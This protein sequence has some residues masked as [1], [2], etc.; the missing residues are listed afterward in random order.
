MR[1]KTTM[2]LLQTPISGGENYLINQLL[3]IICFLVE[4]QIIVI[5]PNGPYNIMLIVTPYFIIY[6]L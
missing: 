5:L 3:N 6:L 4:D 2:R 1:T